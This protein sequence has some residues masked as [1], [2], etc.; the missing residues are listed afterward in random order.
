ML[1]ARKVPKHIKTVEGQAAIRELITVLDWLFKKNERREGRAS[2]EAMTELFLSLF[3]PKNHKPSKKPA[4][5]Q[6]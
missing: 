2:Y 6:S 1:E 3:D 5:K 4:R